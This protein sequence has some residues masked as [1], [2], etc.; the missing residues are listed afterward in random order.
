MPETD[1]QY[2]CDDI[3]KYLISR[4][5]YKSAPADCNRRTINAFR[6]KFDLY[7]R[8]RSPNEFWKANTFV[9]ARVGFKET[10]KRHGTSLLRFLVSRADVYGIKKI[11]IESANINAAAFAS[12]FGFI[13]FCNDNWI[14]DVEELKERLLSS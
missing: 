12:Y 2:L 10:R 11:G 9:I 5:K 4:F 6:K 8:F 1:I 3:N 7:F 13:K 14:I